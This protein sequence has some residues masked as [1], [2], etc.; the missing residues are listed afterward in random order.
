MFLIINRTSTIGIESITGI[1]IQINYKSDLRPLFRVN[2]DPVCY[3][4]W[5]RLRVGRPLWHTKTGN[6]MVKATD[7]F[8]S[9]GMYPFRVGQF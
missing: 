1:S 5:I 6:G 3:F 9:N 2:D 8:M 7:E 4:Q